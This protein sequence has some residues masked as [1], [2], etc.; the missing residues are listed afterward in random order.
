MKNLFQR[1]KGKN[2][3]FI[4]KKKMIKFLFIFQLPSGFK[5]IIFYSKFQLK[6]LTA[7]SV[8]QETKD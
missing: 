6:S 1:K 7:Y 8:M 4:L 2:N 5:N 3:Y